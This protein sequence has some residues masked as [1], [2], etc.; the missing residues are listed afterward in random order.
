MENKTKYWKGLEE[1]NKEPEFVQYAKNEFAEGLP[2]DEILNENNLNLSSN[3]RD[4]LKFFGFSV[5][6][7]ALAACNKAPVKH[8]IP[9]VV[10][11]EEIVPGIPNYY[12]STYKNVPVVVKTR[13]GR[14]IKIE[15]NSKSRI[16]QGGLDA[17][18]QASVVSLYDKH[19]LPIAFKDKK[20]SSWDVVDKEIKS[21]LDAINKTGGKL[22][23]V[24]G[25][26]TSLTGLGAIEI[27]KE[28]Y[29]NT[30]HF[31]Y[32]AINYNGIFEANK[33]TF[34]QA[35]VP[36]YAFDKAEVIVSFGADF[37]GTWL[38]TV[39]YTKDYVKNRVP[40]EDNPKMSR[41]I[42]FES[43]LTLT[44][45]KADYRFPLKASDE[46]LALVNLYNEIAMITGNTQL[47]VVAKIELAGNAIKNTA[48]AL[49]ENKGKSLLVSGSNDAH[50]QAL[51]NQINLILGNYGNTIDV[52]NY[53]LT[54][55]GDDDFA[56]FVKNIDAYAGV[57]FYNCN[58]VFN[59]PNGKQLSDKIQK[60]KLSVSSAFSMD[61]T[62]EHCSYV[63]PDLHY[64]ESWDISEV[65]KGCYSFT[66]PTIAPVF[67]TRQM[68]ESLL[69]WSGNESLKTSESLAY[70][71]TRKIASETV[72][73]GGGDFET[74]WR[75]SLH[76]G[77]Y[78]TKAEAGVSSS[79]ILAKDLLA[80]LNLKK[81][82][83]IDLILMPKVGL[84]DGA[85]GNN[86]W[87]YE[88][89][90]PV[91]KVCWDNYVSIGKI[92]ADELNLKQG[93]LVNVNKDDIS[94][95][96]MPVLIQPGQA[97]NTIGIQLGFGREKGVKEVIGKNA[98]VFV[99]AKGNSMLYTVNDVK[100][101]KVAGSYELA[102]TQT[103]HSIEGRDIVREASLAEFKHNPK[104]A[105]EDHHTI[106]RD[107]KGKL[108]DL[109]KEFEYNGHKWG[110]AID[111]N[112]CT[113]CSACVVSCSIEN[114]VPV[115]GREEV[116]KRREMHW[117]R[118]DRYYSFKNESDDFKTEEKYYD[119]LSNH[120]NVRVVHQPMMCQHCGH[121]PC[122][123]VCP[124]LATTHSSEGLNQMTY[125]RCIGTKY[126]A[127]NCPYKVRRFNWFRY[128]DND[129]FDYYMNND[130]GKMV[131]N[132]DVTVRTRGVMEKCSMCVQ[133]IQAGKLTAKLENRQIKDGDINTACAQSCPANAI[134]F[135]D[136][137]DPESKIAKL[138][139]NKR[140][141][142]A[143]EELNVQPAVRYTTVIRN[144]DEK[145][146]ESNHSHS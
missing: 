46:A 113:G 135:G 49:T 95:T 122:E 14:P 40:S 23:V 10:L 50:I 52:N 92:T 20:T 32:E 33:L 114:N 51:V 74:W 67:E 37:L 2:L 97:R 140:A 143:L 117:I 94:L 76:D 133:R 82:E 34:N 57:I 98:F 9:Y 11:P 28:K 129:N 126:C 16:S 38:N 63:T 54:A 141:Y 60:M 24:S 47:P 118:I 131:I 120:E 134:V 42:Q 127:N 43:L 112:A 89:P 85:E 77:I 108:Y 65:S 146:A 87:L 64:L 130:L 83:G 119:K 144:V 123:T 138:F 13:E 66:Q 71:F 48:K 44:G 106:L 29:N 142:A 116:R 70:D 56:A 1:L 19:R 88:L 53:Y 102:Q 101:E 125:N 96:A 110:L 121:A 3:R 58:P 84:G 27:F 35:V 68:Q 115:V 31:V 145:I 7:V 45:T 111:M 80:N 91:S 21:K 104:V 81:S 26:L 41:H 93:D 103:H 5:S 72:N 61:E 124:V 109:W 8:V 15:G 62:A 59:H 12:A 86:P 36:S 55:S 18:G 78:E 6:A 17:S 4:F 105:N 25:H 99:T 79:S 128:N 30:A 139:A 100:L 137:N 39:Q 69:I 22:A 136:M 107:E 75:S 90:D 73:R 132:P